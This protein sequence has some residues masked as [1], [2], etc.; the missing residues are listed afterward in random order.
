MCSSLHT[1][2]K[3]NFL[4]HKTGKN[5]MS[6]IKAHQKK[7][8]IIAQSD[9]VCQMPEVFSRRT[10]EHQMKFLKSYSYVLLWLV[11]N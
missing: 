2:S 4:A 7:K 3:E 10:W 8:I 5:D 6:K 1:E 9:M 11:N